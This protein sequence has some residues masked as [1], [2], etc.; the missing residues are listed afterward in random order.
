MSND[1]NAAHRMA[2]AGRH[3][4]ATWRE[5]IDEFLASHSLVWEIAFAALALVYVGLD[6]AFEHATGST[7]QAVDAIELG[8]TAVFV[9]EF[10]IR[11]WAAPDRSVH[12]RR[13]WIDA[14]SLLP[15]VRAFRVLRVLRLIRVFSGVYRAGLDFDRLAQHRAFL[16]VVI[17]WLALG[18]VCSVAFF[19]AENAGGQTRSAFD[20]LWWAVGSLS[21]VGSDIFPATA[22]GKVAAMVLEIFGVFLFSAITATITSFLLASNSQ[23]KSSA[24]LAVE[25]ARVSELHEAGRL[26]DEEFGKAKAL[27]LLTR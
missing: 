17:S 18:A 9:I 10:F 1:F 20:A 6:L 26:T 19:A 13:H 15:P 3:R 22:E 21:T 5:K 14:V 23:E 16:S 24:G 27:L 2:E 8:L 11:L 12:L 7:A 4:P 25:L